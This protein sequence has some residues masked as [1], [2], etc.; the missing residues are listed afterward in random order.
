M[1]ISYF[2]DKELHNWFQN[3]Q[4]YQNYCIK[5]LP[6]FV[7]IRRRKWVLSLS[8]QTFQ[9]FYSVKVFPSWSW[10][11]YYKSSWIPYISSKHVNK[12]SKKIATSEKFQIIQPFFHWQ[13]RIF[14]CLVWQFNRVTSQLLSTC[15]GSGTPTP[16][17]RDTNTA[18]IDAR[19]S[20]QIW[21]W[22]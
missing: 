4:N 14:C 8:I 13:I 10:I 19:N 7:E 1:Y 20:H 17:T 18:K 22:R 12:F 21:I 16:W 11:D 5:M 15:L 2:F 9:H 3:F 6:Y